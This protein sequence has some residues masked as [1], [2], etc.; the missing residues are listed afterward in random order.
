MIN[1]KTFLYSLA[2]AY[3]FFLVIFGVEPQMKLWDNVPIKD[4]DLAEYMAGNAKV[5]GDGLPSRAM[6]V[7]AYPGAKIGRLL[8]NSLCPR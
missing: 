3:A 8:H 7:M 2:I 6:A 5:N 1:L 4:T